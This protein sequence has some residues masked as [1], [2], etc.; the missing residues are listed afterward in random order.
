MD[1]GDDP[2]DYQNTW[3]PLL[4]SD[5]GSYRVVEC[6]EGSNQGKVLDYDVESGICVQFNSLESMFLTV[7]EF[8]SEGLYTIVNDRIEWST[9]YKKFNEIGAR[10]NPG[11]GYWK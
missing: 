8:W 10:L 4:F 2:E 11:A 7:H 6:G 1:T 3:F 9:D 5:S